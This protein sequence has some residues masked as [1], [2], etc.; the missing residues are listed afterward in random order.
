[1]PKRTFYTAKEVCE[2]LQ[3]SKKTLFKWEREGEIP[4]IQRD[5]RMW[6]MYSEED[7]ERIRLLIERKR[8]EKMERIGQRVG[9]DEAC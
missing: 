9:D 2:R 1:M 4:S 6:R 8:K 5:W 7:V 3:V